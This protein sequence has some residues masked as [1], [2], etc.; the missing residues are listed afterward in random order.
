MEF[1]LTDIFCLRA[2]IPSS[3]SGFTMF[4]TDRRRLADLEEKPRT[5]TDGR[6]IDTQRERT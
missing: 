3:L 1:A 2:L 6:E 4:V 5:T